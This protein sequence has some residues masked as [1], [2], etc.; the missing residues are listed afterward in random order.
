[1][2]GRAGWLVCRSSIQRD[3]LV[4]LVEVRLSAGVPVRCVPAALVVPSVRRCMTCFLRSLNSSHT[5]VT[6]FPSLI[7]STT[8]ASLDIV[9][10]FLAHQIMYSHER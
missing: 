3:P 7:R 4:P 8:M 10:A 2:C 6:R 5:A 1:M 9:R